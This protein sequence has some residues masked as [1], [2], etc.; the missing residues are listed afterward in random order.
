MIFNLDY[1]SFSTR[2]ERAKLSGDE[3][4][5][6]APK[7]VVTITLPS[8]FLLPQNLLKIPL[9]FQ[10][11]IDFCFVR[12]SEIELYLLLCLPAHSFHH[13]EK[14]DVATLEKC[15]LAESE[16]FLLLSFCKPS[17]FSS[18]K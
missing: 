4:K 11:N 8:P 6:S 7:D 1:F 9:N 10:F 5:I 18:F 15:L 2:R 3:A 13:C 14:M 17:T 12:S 16:G